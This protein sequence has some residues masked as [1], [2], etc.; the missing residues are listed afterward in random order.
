MSEDT[1]LVGAIIELISV[2][3]LICAAVVIIWAAYITYKG[4]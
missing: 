1:Q 3:T 4:E 2:A